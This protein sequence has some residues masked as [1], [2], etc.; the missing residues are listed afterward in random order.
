MVFVL[1][2]PDNLSQNGA[3]YKSAIDSAVACLAHSGLTFLPQPQATPDMTVY[4]WPGSILTDGSLT[5]VF[6]Q[7]SPT[8]VAP[9]GNPRIDRIV[10][11][12]A[13]GAI[14][15]VAGT[16]AASPVA[17]AIP[18][19]R[20]PICK[21][22]LQPSSTVISASMITDERAMPT[23]TAA[24]RDV[25]TG[26][27]QIP[28]NA[29][30]VVAVATITAGEALAA[31]DV[32][33]QDIFNQRAG[34]ATKWYKV[35]TDA[36]GPV[37]ISPRIGMALAA[38][39]S[40]ATGLAQV[41]PGRVAGFTGL[42]AGAPVWASTTAGGITQ[43][44]PSLPSSGTQNAIRLIGIAASTT[45]IDFDPDDD[46][47]F[48]K[49]NDTLA[50][51]SSITVEHW[52]DTGAPDRVPFASAIGTT[53]ATTASRSN[54]SAGTG[55][56]GYTVRAKFAAS[57]LSTNGSQV[58][59]TLRSGGQA[60]TINNCYIGEAAASGNAWDFAATPTR[61]TFDGGSNGFSGLSSSTN[62]ASDLVTFT[63]DETK[64]YIVSFEVS[65]TGGPYGLDFVAFPSG[66]TL[67]YK[68]GG[69]ADAGSTA[70]SGYTTEPTNTFGILSIEVVTSTRREPETI[71]PEGRFSGA[72]DKITCRYDDGAGANA[73]TKTTFV[74]RT[75]TVQA[76]AAE[77]VL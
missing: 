36:V 38:I 17:P 56:T 40:G 59:V 30:I 37:K 60:L 39:S 42:T 2:I 41:R 18:T 74:N 65:N 22:T 11:N 32:I 61:I 49:T 54:G 67:Y 44:A 45:E 28:T 47:L 55:Y 70:P 50:S 58:R 75:S 35:D 46:T 21:V 66:W 68:T 7:S 5:S 12:P 31:N 23:G 34:G 57:A 43:T 14:Q 19:N 33:Y 52:T 64:N 8:F 16:P 51:G 3:V 1:T 15:V 72:T 24:L 4:I 29:D 27:T 26:A 9:V 10:L 53:I 71:F 69:V 77:V 76:L 13:T 73:D 20:L 62:K 25:G 6:A 63:L 48:V